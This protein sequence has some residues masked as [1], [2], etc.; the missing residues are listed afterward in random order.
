MDGLLETINAVDLTF[1]FA[2]LLLPTFKVL[3]QLLPDGFLGC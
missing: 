3:N 1:L 2:Q